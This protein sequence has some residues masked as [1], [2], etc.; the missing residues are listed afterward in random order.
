MTTDVYKYDKS[1]WS[2]SFYYDGIIKNQVDSDDYPLPTIDDCQ[3]CFDFVIE[4]GI[5]LQELTS[6]GQIVE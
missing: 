1:D 4:T 5:R 2:S 6:Y 3:F